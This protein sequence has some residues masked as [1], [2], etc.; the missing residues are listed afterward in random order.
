MEYGPYNIKQPK[1]DVSKNIS[2][3]QID[4]VVVP[5]VAFDRQNNRLGRGAGYYDR[6]IKKIGLKIWYKKEY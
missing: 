4:M 2:M 3:S 5:A 6:F 1:E